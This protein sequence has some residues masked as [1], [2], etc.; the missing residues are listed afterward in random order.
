MMEY[1]KNFFAVVSSKIFSGDDG[2]DVRF[3]RPPSPHVRFGEMFDDPPFKTL[4]SGQ[5]LG[6]GIARGPGSGPTQKRGWS[7]VSVGPP[8]K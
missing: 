4:V 8:V 7:E 5:P 1:E 6:S 3:C 2:V